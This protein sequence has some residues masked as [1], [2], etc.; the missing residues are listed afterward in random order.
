MWEAAWAQKL[1]RGHVSR[2]EAVAWIST[3]FDEMFDLKREKDGKV[4]F[5]AFEVRKLPSHTLVQRADLL[6]RQRDPFEFGSRVVATS[7]GSQVKIL[8]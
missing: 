7:A 4:D 6:T 5:V 1:S 2:E 8:P 3:N